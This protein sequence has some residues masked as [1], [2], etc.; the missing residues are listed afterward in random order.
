M[1]LMERWRAKVAARSLW[2]KVLKMGEE[3]QKERKKSK[4]LRAMG[5]YFPAFESVLD[6][7]VA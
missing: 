7:E 6:G 2:W 1:W 4:K 5:I 3:N